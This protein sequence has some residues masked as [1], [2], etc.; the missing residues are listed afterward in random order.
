M[1]DEDDFAIGGSW[2][3]PDDDAQGSSLQ[4]IMDWR[5]PCDAC[6]AI[7]QG[8]DSLTIDPRFLMITDTSQPPQLIQPYVS[9]FS[10]DSSSDTPSPNTRLGY[11]GGFVHDTEPCPV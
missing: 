8:Q 6:H 1:R 7:S 2:P 3:A 5:G 10:A 4:S 9:P 11:Q